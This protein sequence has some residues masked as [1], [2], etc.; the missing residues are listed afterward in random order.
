MMS[1]TSALAWKRC[2]VARAWKSTAGTA[3]EGLRLVAEELPDVIVLDIRLGDRLGLQVFHDI[4]EL[5]P[6]CLVIFITG[7]GTADTAIEAMK[8]GAYDYLI[9]PLDPSNLSRSSSRPL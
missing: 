7:H 2:S 8:L 6:K 4:R 9:K 1:R 3:E 5:D